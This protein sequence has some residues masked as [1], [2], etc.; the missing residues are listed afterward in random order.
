MSETDND[1]RM[2]WAF[3]ATATAEP[4]VDSMTRIF[5]KLVA[6]EELTR[7][8][9]NRLAFIGTAATVRNMG[10]AFPFGQFLPSFVVRVKHYGWQEVL[11]YDRTAIR[12]HSTEG[13]NVERIVSLDPALR[14]P[15][16]PKDPK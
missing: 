10:W 2:P 1:I 6:G 16:A 11:A 4:P 14:G 13:K 5:D 8:E 9:K 12:S 7:E 3:S 15:L